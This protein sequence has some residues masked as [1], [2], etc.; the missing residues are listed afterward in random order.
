MS[1]QPIG[2]FDSGVGGLSIFK[3]ITTLM[4]NENIVYLADSNNAPYG[5]KS[6]AEITALCCKNTDNLLSLN[7]KL[8]VVAC[9]TATTNAIDTLRK[10]Y[11]IP[12]IGIE[13]AI[14]PAALNTK[15][16][17]IGILATK[18]TLS[19]KLFHHTAKLY[20]GDI[21]V[22]ERNGDGIVELIETG[23]LHSPELKKLVEGYV[24]PMLAE[25][26]DQLVLGCT[27][28]TFLIPML[29]N[30]LPKGVTIVDPGRAVAKQTLN[31]LE[32]NN[33]KN[34]S[35]NKGEVQLFSNADAKLLQD[36]AG[37]YQAELKDF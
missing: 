5:E 27:H 19:S 31:I 8:V 29:N 16:K 23:N 30:F 14:K 2:I 9:N 4:P 24:I 3:E 33:L 6:A 32:K 15:S 34:P 20:G 36:L 1:K 11:S 13:P 21:R 12:F 25:N 22:I 10:K 35:D 28:Y 18:G 7:C 17:V 26:I 37:D